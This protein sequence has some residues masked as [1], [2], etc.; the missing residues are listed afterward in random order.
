[1]N[2]LAVVAIGGNSLV[3][4]RDAS[5]GAARAALAETAG[6]LA[7]MA[8][9]GWTLAITHGNGPQV[10]FGL[11]RSDAASGVAPRLPLD[12]LG[13]ETQG[14][15]GYL[16][17]Q[18]L[19]EAFTARGVDRHVATL[20]TQV[21]VDPRDP[22]FT[23]P[24]KP[25]GPFYSRHEA[26]RRTREERWTMVEDAGRGW[27]R[28]VPSPEPLAIVEAPVIRAL[29]LQGVVVVAAGGGGIPVV[30]REAGFHG[31]EAVVDKDLASAV[32]ARELGARLLLMSTPVERV[33]LHYGTPAE[34]AI[35][36]MSA[37]DAHR[38]LDEGHFPPGSMGPKIQ[39]A[40]RF[41]EAEGDTVIVTAPWAIS[42]AL[43]GRTGTRIKGDAS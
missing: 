34:Q 11:L 41:L 32:L 29:L 4:D 27:R 26:E 38:Y 24:A 10:G 16:L 30:R 43:A 40:I 37:R 17:Q 25:I 18:A 28:V 8:A 42:E 15:I 6:H 5:V 33:A 36:E 7:M 13:A 19:T 2:G 23:D 22:A 31:I 12:V 21:I 14:S 20:V 35:G 9:A 3:R 1:M 39:A